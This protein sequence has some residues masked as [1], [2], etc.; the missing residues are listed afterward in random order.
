MSLR[1]AH[2]SQRVSC[3]SNYSA[4]SQH[5]TLACVTLNGE[6][7]DSKGGS[8]DGGDSADDF[9]YHSR[10]QSAPLSWNGGGD[11]DS[12]GGGDFEAMLGRHMRQSLTMP[13]CTH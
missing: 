12:S 8:E 4:H 2:S 1:R 7:P 5:K 9:T 3:H 11:S 10:S 13:A 6:L